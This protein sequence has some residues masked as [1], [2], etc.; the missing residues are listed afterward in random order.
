[1]EDVDD[2]Q[3][4]GQRS[5]DVIGF[6]AVH[7]LL[8][9]IQHVGAED[10]NGQHGD[11]NHAGGRLGEHIDDATHEQHDDANH[12]P[13][14]HARQIAFDDGGQTGHQEEHAC[15]AAKGCHHQVCAVFKAQNH[16]NHAREHQT[17]EEG[18]AQQHVH[19]SDAFFGALN[20]VDE[21]KRAGEH[22]NH[23]QAT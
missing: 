3:V 15:R 9:V 6:T 20:G 11:H 2:V 14:V 5:A 12:Q 21:A 8:E 4:Q 17:H 18:K 7:D 13:F 23:A 10:G 1:L 22:Q 19:A 16:G